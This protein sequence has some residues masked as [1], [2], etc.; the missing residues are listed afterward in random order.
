MLA[1]SL[2]VGV[3]VASAV[4]SLLV[5]DTLVFVEDRYH[6]DVATLALLAPT[7]WAFVA[8]ISSWASRS[9]DGRS[10]GLAQHRLSPA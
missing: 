9:R 8:R 10:L 4:L 7:T 2:P 3:A 1:S 6:V 5:L